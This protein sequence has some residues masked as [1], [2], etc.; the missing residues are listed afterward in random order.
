[1]DTHGSLWGQTLP[2]SDFTLTEQGLWGETRSTL[3]GGPALAGLNPPLFLFCRSGRLLL[4]RVQRYLWLGSLTLGALLFRWWAW[5]MR[6]AD[7][8]GESR[9]AVL[10]FSGHVGPTR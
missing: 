4:P 9:K 2:E 3:E 6:P 10:S 8:T 7:E 1:M 5:L